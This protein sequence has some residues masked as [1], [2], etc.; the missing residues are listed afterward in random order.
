MGSLLGRHTYKETRKVGVC[1]GAVDTWVV[2]PEVE[3]VRKFWSWVS[4]PELFFIGSKE[5]EI[6]HPYFSHPSSHTIF[7]VEHNLQW[8]CTVAEASSSDKH[9]SPFSHQ[10]RYGHTSPRKGSG[11]RIIYQLVEDSIKL[12][13]RLK[14]GIR[15]GS[16][17]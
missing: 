3:S 4:P 14:N 10:L 15:F 16:E 12:G 9:K 2:A 7:W 6:L 17:K 13:Q 8:K 5:A 1:R 11:Q